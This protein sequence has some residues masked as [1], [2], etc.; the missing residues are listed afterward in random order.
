[1]E[2]SFAG[3]KSKNQLT[4]PTDFEFQNQFVKIDFQKRMTTDV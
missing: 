4:S 2:A 1:M 3:S